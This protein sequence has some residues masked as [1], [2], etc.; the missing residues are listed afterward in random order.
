MK[1]IKIMMI[2]THR[3]LLCFLVGLLAVPPRLVSS[4]SWVIK[5]GLEGGKSRGGSDGD[6][7]TLQRYFCPLDLLSDW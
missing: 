1:A 5:V 6:D 3:H 2:K 7:L 4:H